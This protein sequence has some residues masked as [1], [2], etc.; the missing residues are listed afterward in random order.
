MLYFIYEIMNFFLRD[1]S[2]TFMFPPNIKI[3]HLFFIQF[4]NVEKEKQGSKKNMIVFCE[5]R[6]QQDI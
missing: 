3:Y 4:S 5:D 1:F 6:H 2:F